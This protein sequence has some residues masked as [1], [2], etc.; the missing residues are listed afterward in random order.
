MKKV[1]F[2]IGGPGCGKTETEM[3]IKKHLS[4]Q[5]FVSLTTRDPREEEIEGI[6]Y[7]FRS[8]E[9]FFKEEL[10]NIIRISSGWYYGVPKSELNKNTDIFVYSVINLYPAI[11]LMESIKKIDSN[12]Q[13]L[14]VFFDIPKEDRIQM[15]IERAGY[16]KEEAVNRLNRPAYEESLKD[17]IDAN[18]PVDYRVTEFSDDMQDKIINFIKETAKEVA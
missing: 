9:K 8:P 11:E 4:A 13:F 2:L 14:T 1:I 10:L 17:F 12:I 7:Y 16:T 6:H 5:S 3:D 18:I 15:L